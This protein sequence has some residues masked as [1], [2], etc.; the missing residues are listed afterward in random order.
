M[1]NFDWRTDE[2]ETVWES[3][4]PPPTPPQKRTWRWPWLVAVVV[5]A[6]VAGG[7]GYQ[8][9]NKRLAHQLESIRADILTTHYLIQKS[10]QTQD[11]DLFYPLLSGRDT[12]WANMQK[13][14]VAQGE[15]LDRS[16][17]GLSSL[18]LPIPL[19]D[20]TK[21]DETIVD[22]DVA[23]DLNT[24]TLVW[25]Q[26]YTAVLPSGEVALRLE[27]TAVYRRGSERWLYAPPD[28][29]FWGP[30]QQADYAHLQFIYPQRDGEWASRLG[31][32]LNSQIEILCQKWPPLACADDFVMTV[33]LQTDP[34]RLAY[35]A[36]LNQ[37]R[38]ID[39]P[40]LTLVG[41]PIDELG[42]AVLAQGYARQVITAVI[43]QQTGWQCCDHLLFFQA[44][45]DYQL[46]QMGL[47]TWPITSDDYVR[48]VNEG[49][50][51]DNFVDFWTVSD[52]GQ[53]HQQD[54]WQVYTVVDFLITVNPDE[55]PAQLQSLLL[56]HQSMLFWVN[57][58]YAGRPDMGQNSLLWS[59]LQTQWQDMLVARSQAFDAP[60]PIALP[61]QALYLLCNPTNDNAPALT[62]L[63]SYDFTT[64]RL[65]V[66]RSIPAFALMSPTP[67]DQALILQEFGFET[68]FWQ[69]E[70]WHNGGVNPLYIGDETYAVFFGESSP[71][72]RWLTMYQFNQQDQQPTP[73]I[74]D[75]QNCNTHGCAT[76]I[77]PGSLP[78]WSPDSSQWLFTESVFLESGLINLQGRAT[79][80]QPDGGQFLATPIYRGLPQGT[81]VD[82]DTLVGNGYSPFWID[83][84]TYG[85]VEL[86]DE[87]ETV[88]IAST[89]DDI[90]LP[91][92]TRT[93][94]WHFFA[95]N[96]PQENPH[97]LSIRYAIAHPN[98]PNLLFIGVVDT[99]TDTI[100]ILSWDRTTQKLIFN[101]KLRYKYEHSLSFS[102]DGQWLVVS[103]VDNSPSSAATSS[104]VL[105]F[106]HLADGQ[107]QKFLLRN[108]TSFPSM[109]YDW[110]SDGKWVAILINNL[111]FALFAPD[112]GYQRVVYFGPSNCGSLSWVDTSSP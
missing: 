77:A 110:S 1:A 111:A 62:T 60:A 64:Q 56:S 97:T 55:T 76:Q 92:V 36:L 73:I 45:L 89:Q 105:L 44:L 8:Q 103:G 51:L 58:V 39:L 102:P 104:S 59:K 13:T 81:A 28:N 29:A 79:L 98:N 107:T 100:Y 68:N 18:P 86:G 57:Q 43:I 95:D 54:I 9:F 66:A 5:L 85:F 47:Q 46:S 27:Q 7:L 11:E 19:E 74:L 106:Y 61:E 23:A 26:P 10:A 17:L 108:E 16:P 101:L 96:L 88:V 21:G 40:S 48:A 49:I 80:I 72:G 34:D 87:G 50:T 33:R 31:Q 6:S 112:E 32:Q 93:D 2:D 69:T 84:Q 41:A 78:V 52:L 63:N 15:F 67:D 83:N 25:T 94:L 70:R 24:A 90:P 3:P 4:A 82:T 37:G 109:P 38:E 65:A 71:N 75:T 12:A 35:S 42:F 99:S 30:W 22:L 20:M 53:L 14:L 91:L